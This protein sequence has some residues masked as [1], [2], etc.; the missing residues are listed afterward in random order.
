MIQSILFLSKSFAILV[1]WG[2]ITHLPL[3]RIRQLGLVRGLT[4]PLPTIPQGMRCFPYI[5]FTEFFG[6]MFSFFQQAFTK[7][8]IS[9]TEDRK[10]K[11]L[12]FRSS[13]VWKQM[14]TASWY[15]HFNFWP[16]SP[17]LP[18]QPELFFFFL[19]ITQ[20]ISLSCLKLSFTLIFRI[21]H[22]SFPTSLHYL[23]PAYLSSHPPCPQFYSNAKFLSVLWTY[24]AHSC[25]GAFLVLPEWNH[26]SRIIF[27]QSWF[28][29][30]LQV[31]TQKFLSSDMASLKTWINK[32]LPSRLPTFPPSWNIEF[33]YLFSCLLS[34]FSNS[35]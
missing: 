23:A 22:H 1:P 29:S 34:F 21:K 24:P 20:I 26:L 15:S 5:E 3:L 28:L 9:S 12:P 17:L 13:R 27:T 2:I 33:I 35:M 31:L 19:N 6:S 16:S 14:T 32:P 30:I 7:C 10:M 4:Q 8:C 18:K 25:T 11:Q